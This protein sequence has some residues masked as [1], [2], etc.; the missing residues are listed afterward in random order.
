[1]HRT[2]LVAMTPDEAG[3]DALALGV[4]LARPSGA[5]V[6]LGGVVVQ[7]RGRPVY[8]GSA[9]DE[10][11]TRLRELSRRRAYDVAV[12]AEVVMSASVPLGLRDLA[13]ERQAD[14]LVLGASH[15][16]TLERVLHGDLAVEAASSAPCPVAVAAH[17]HAAH[18]LARI[19]VGWDGTPEGDDALEWAVQFADAAGAT[20]QI[21]RVLEARHRE[22]TVPEPT[23]REDAEAARRR[24]QHRVLAD[25]KL[26]WG[27]PGRALV[28]AS[29]DVDLLVV[30]ARPHGPLRRM[31]FW[32]ATTSVLHNTHCPVVVLPRGVHVPARAAMV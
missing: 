8:E 19:A 23:A 29:R 20:V 32:N 14:L 25:T 16:G 10:L 9:F 3:R 31:L 7:R 30:G 4:E 17:G 15:G 28:E 26:V 22:G 11:L 1:M 27:D 18:E 21:V 12:S 13:T 6:I 5:N 2:I 24:V